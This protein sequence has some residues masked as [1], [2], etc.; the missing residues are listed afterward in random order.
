MILDL[1]DKIERT[2]DCFSFCFKSKEKF[3]WKAG[4]YMQFT[5]KHDNPDDR[6]VNRFFTIS[7]A[8]EEE[9]I[10]IT[11]RYAGERS[12]T[13]KKALFNMG[14]GGSILSSLP[15]GEFIIDDLNK[16]YVM[17]AGG[18][19][20]TPFRSILI[21]LEYRRK[22]EG[23]SVSLLYCNRNDMIVFKDEFD[24]IA[25]NSG[26]FKIR[27]VIKPEVC[28]LDLIKITIPDYGEK[29]YYISGPPGMVKAIE[30]SLLEDG[31]PQKQL[32][33]DYFPGY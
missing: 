15:M 21:D 12:S 14:I 20:V 3:T 28:D 19:G 18:I 10:M 4:Q 29:T 30:D 6:G 27:Y 31:I 13:F 8:P 5:L 25:A 2:P 7:S 9:M 22:L 23:L 33:L 32:Q 11:T 16:S 1:F 26:T 24:I 17:V